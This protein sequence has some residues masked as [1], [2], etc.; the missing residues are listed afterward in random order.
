M[1]A[2]EFVVFAL[3]SWLLGSAIFFLFVLS[4]WMFDGNMAARKFAGRLL[5]VLVWPLA[6]FSR[7]GRTALFGKL[8]GI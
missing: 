5:F 1:A 4:D 3:R 8:E 2:Y 6:L 7:K